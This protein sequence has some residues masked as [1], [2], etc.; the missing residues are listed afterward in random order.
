MNKEIKLNEKYAII[1]IPETA[2][3][4]ELN[5]KVFTGG[6]VEKVSRT[7][8]M[9]EIREAFSEY[10]EAEDCGYIPPDA[11]FILTDKGRKMI[12]E[13]LEQEKV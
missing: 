5:V 11:T 1:S 13:L 12:E 8:S 4:V 9:E 3:E 2:V 7:L 6:G 10:E